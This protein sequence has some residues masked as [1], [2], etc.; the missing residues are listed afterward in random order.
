MAFVHIFQ[1]GLDAFL[2]VAAKHNARRDQG[3]GGIEAHIARGIQQ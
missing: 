2:L 3:L 1:D